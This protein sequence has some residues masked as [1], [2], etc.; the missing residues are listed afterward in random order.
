MSFSPPKTGRRPPVIDDPAV[1]EA[2]RRA[3]EAERLRRG[4]AATILTG[5]QGV[6]GDP[7]V[8]RATLLGG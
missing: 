3:L 1:E 5:N 4:R 7:V 2:R 8:G 6:T